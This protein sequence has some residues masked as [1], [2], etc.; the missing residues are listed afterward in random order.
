MK[1][2]FAKIYASFFFRDAIGIAVPNSDDESRHVTL[3]P[4]KKSFVRGLPTDTGVAFVVTLFLGCFVVTVRLRPYVI[5]S[6]HCQ[7][8]CLVYF[9]AET[10]L[11][12][13]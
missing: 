12:N 13:V 5:N 3:L 7:L 8:A 4:Q 1:S 9:V 11:V 2:L 10:S 6:M